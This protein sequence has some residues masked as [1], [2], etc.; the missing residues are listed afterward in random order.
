MPKPSRV[1]QPEKTETAVTAPNAEW[2][3][4]IPAL[5]VLLSAAREFSGAHSVA[6]ALSVDL[7]DL[8]VSLG[9]EKDLASIPI[10]HLVGRAGLAEQVVDD[11]EAVSGQLADRDWLILQQRVFSTEPRSLEELGKEL[12]L[13]RE[14]VRQLEARA[15]R[16]LKARVIPK[17]DRIAQVVR[18]R[19]GHV[20]SQVN[21]EEE[22]NGLFVDD[23]RPGTEIARHMLAT[24]LNY[25]VVNEIGMDQS[26]L[27]VVNILNEAARDL[28]DPG[29]LIDEEALRG[30]LPDAAWNRYWNALIFRAGL[31][32]LCGHLAVR[33]TIPAK[34]KAAVISIGRPAT[35]EEISALVGCDPKR[36]GARVSR[37]RGIARADKTRWG[38]EEWIDDVYEGIPAE[39]IQRI[40]EDGGATTL[41]R[42]VTELPRLFGV[43]ELSVRAHVQTPQFI[44]KD[45][46]VSLA[47]ASSIQYRHLEDV[48][49]GR[50]ESGAPYW[51]FL[52]KEQY[53][54]GYSLGGFPPELAREL[55]CGPDEKIRVPLGR[56]AGFQDL[57]L[58][59]RTSAVSGATVGYLAAPLKRLG[60]RVGD[61]VILVLMP[62]RSVELRKQIGSKTSLSAESADAILEQLKRRRQV[63]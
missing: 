40:E 16:A 14:R 6:D 18:R 10:E 25:S 48:I 59:W 46:Y 15:R 52:V 34:I 31:P 41:E 17:V 30:R 33:S 45:G 42:L 19:L 11:V 60:A 44:L 28:A 35:R 49:D 26:A 22:I 29:G 43:S 57:S 7:L 27:G 32:R 56:P 13:T 53:L 3:Q 58:I 9:V 61:E 1:D 63:L 38:L 21:I 39:I 5:E 37:V 20:V 24:A 51:T 54:N 12:G 36:V 50:D 55:G 4:A 47:D 23:T 8:A 2:S 62:D